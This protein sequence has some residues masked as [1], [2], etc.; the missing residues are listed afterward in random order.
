MRVRFCW[1][2]KKQEINSASVSPH[3][4]SLCLCLLFVSACPQ[5]IPF[6]KQYITMNQMLWEGPLSHC[7][8]S[9]PLI[10]TT[11][12]F[13]QTLLLVCISPLYKCSA[14]YVKTLHIILETLLFHPA[15]YSCNILTRST[16]SPDVFQKCR[17]CRCMKY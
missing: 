16:T 13:L 2:G 11:P 4:A 7:L 14:L 8:V 15:V 12:S 17:Y 3:P 6:I 9:R 10:I 5:L 1:G